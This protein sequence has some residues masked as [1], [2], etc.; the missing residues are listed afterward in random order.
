MDTVEFGLI[1]FF[2]V[3]MLPVIASIMNTTP[4]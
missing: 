2:T 4:L 1:S 3:V